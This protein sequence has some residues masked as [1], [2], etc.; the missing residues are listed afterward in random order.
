MTEILKTTEETL[1]VILNLKGWMWLN[2]TT[3]THKLIDLGRK[4]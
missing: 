3:T 4:D 1:D 2:M